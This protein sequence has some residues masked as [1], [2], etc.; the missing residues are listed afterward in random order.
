VDMKV[1]NIYIKL[2][3]VDITQLLLHNMD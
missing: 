1:V 2:R 3:V